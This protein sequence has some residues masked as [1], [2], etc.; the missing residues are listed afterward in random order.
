[1]KPWCSYKLG[2]YKKKSVNAKNY[3]NLL[4]RKINFEIHT[5]YESDQYKTIQL[6]MRGQ[7][8]YIKQHALRYWVA[9]DFPK[10]FDLSK[11]ISHLCHKRSCVK[12]SHLNH[13]SRAINNARKH[14]LK[15]LSCAG[16]DPEP[17][18]LFWV[19]VSLSLFPVSGMKTYLT[20]VTSLLTS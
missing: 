3:K 15:A 1:M 5:G 10:D 16:H 8:I 20:L 2:S 9:N 6:T 18:C 14:C 17:D 7:K 13:E 11:D 19:C 4:L 12:L